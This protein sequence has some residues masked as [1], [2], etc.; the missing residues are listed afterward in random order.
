MSGSE[1]RGDFSEDLHHPRIPSPAVGPRVLRQGKQRSTRGGARSAWTRSHTGPPSQ[2]PL[3]PHSH[4]TKQVLVPSDASAHLRLREIYNRPEV[5][6]LISDTAGV[7]PRPTG[8]Q[9]LLLQPAP[10]P[11]CPD[12][13]SRRGQAAASPCL[14]CVLQ[15]P[16]PGPRHRGAPLPLTTQELLPACGLGGNQDDQPSAGRSPLQSCFLPLQPSEGRQ[17]RPSPALPALWGVLCSSH[18]SVS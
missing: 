2:D 15:L 16:S 12:S 9:T 17:T 5:T 3:H 11:L 6:L 14:S 13:V 7:Q 1:G 8:L 18:T 4:P 10:R